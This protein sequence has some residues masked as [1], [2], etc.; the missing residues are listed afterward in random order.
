MPYY[1]VEVYEPNTP[2]DISFRIIKA[3]NKTDAKEKVRLE[4][5]KEGH[6]ETTF[7]L[8]EV[9]TALKEFI[10]NKKEL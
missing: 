7:M 5:I 4:L 2:W 9:T 1:E 3:K 8:G 6:K 10:K